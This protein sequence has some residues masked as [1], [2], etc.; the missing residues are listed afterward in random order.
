MLETRFSLKWHTETKPMP[1]FVLV[2]MNAER[3]GPGL[4]PI[5]KD[6][7]QD[8]VTRTSPCRFQM[9]SD[10]KKIGETTWVSIFGRIRAAAAAERHVVD[11]TG[12]SGSFLVDATW[13]SRPDDGLPSIFTA[14]REQMGLRLEPRT[15]PVEIFVID[16]IE[17]PTPN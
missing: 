11:R 1:V 4:E 16:S 9:R 5:E 3:L 17:R 12:L 7:T 6:C 13:T 2:R 14:V 10:G 15:E 8:I